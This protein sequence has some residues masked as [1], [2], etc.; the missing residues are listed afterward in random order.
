MEVYEFYS[1]QANSLRVF[2]EG[3]RIT[4]EQIEYHTERF[5]I[6]LVQCLAFNLLTEEQ[7]DELKA[8]LPT[9]I[10]PSP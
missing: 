1:R 6:N 5:K 10:S 2:L 3:D 9:P 4:Q 7:V 8:R